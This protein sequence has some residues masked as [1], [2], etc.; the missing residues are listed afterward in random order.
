MSLRVVSVWQPAT[1]QDAG[2]RGYL[3]FGVPW[4]GAWDREAM[5]LANALLDNEPDAACLE[6]TSAGGSFVAEEN[7]WV[8]VA[9]SCRTVEIGGF[10]GPGD[11]RMNVLKGAV[12]TLSPSRLSGPTY[13]A[14]PGGVRGHRI[15]GSVSGGRI[16]QGD[17]LLPHA[18]QAFETEHRLARTPSKIEIVP[19]APC[20]EGSELGPVEARYTVSP[21]AD[22]RGLRLIGPPLGPLAERVSRPMCVGA[23][24]VSGDGQPL[25]LG[26]DGPTIGGYPVIGVVPP[27]ALPTLARLGAG[28]IVTLRSVSPELEREQGRAVQTALER[29]FRRVRLAASAA[30]V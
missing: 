30:R 4:G 19:F 7:V 22:R 21:H 16:S 24:Q 23:I 13:L 15:L 17:L 20:L 12:L 18:N 2:R 8:A 1:L 27:W 6:L 28:D 10:E 11:R 14:L 3:R 26:P 9:G 29:E 5:S 25:I